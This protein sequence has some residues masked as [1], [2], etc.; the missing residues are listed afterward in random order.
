MHNGHKTLMITYLVQSILGL[1]KIETLQNHENV[2][3][4]K[5]AYDIIEQYFSEEVWH[6]QIFW[7]CIGHLKLYF[8]RRWRRIRILFQK[9]VRTGFNLMLIPVSLKKDSNSKS[10]VVEYLNKNGVKY[11]KTIEEIMGELFFC[12]LEWTPVVFSS[13]ILFLVL[14]FPS[15]L[16]STASSTVN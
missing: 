2:D 4:Y 11:R 12:Q 3:I 13:I 7:F 9:L 5:L 6:L 8:F 16:T 14:F 1:D 15:H 10:M